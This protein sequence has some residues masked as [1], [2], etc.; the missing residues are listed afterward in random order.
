MSQSYLSHADVARQITDDTPPPYVD[1]SVPVE[2][3]QKRRSVMRVFSKDS[4]GR[5]SFQS[6]VRK[7]S[8]EDPLEMLRKYDT[9]IIVDDSGSM[10]GPRWEEATSALAGLA[11]IAAQYDSDGIDIYFLNHP[12][13]ARG[14][15]DAAQVQELFQHIR[16]YGYTPT[17]ERLEAL[18]NDYIEKLES[19]KAQQ[20]KGNSRALKSIKPINFL[21]ITDGQPTDDPI[22]VIVAAARRLDSGHFPLS[23]VGIQFVQVGDVKLATDYLKALDDE[24]HETHKIRD[25]V[26]TTPYSNVPLTEELLVKV[27]LGGINRRV[28]NH[29]AQSV[30]AS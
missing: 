1:S 2:P 12:S 26:D 10:R 20:T 11:K 8:G 16:P 30:M 27:L 28:D 25:I 3:S 21:V 17:G 4:A 6:P 13:T 22:S 5:P 29:G 24:L 23:Q 15:K 9:V 7:D 19:A 14:M 18:L